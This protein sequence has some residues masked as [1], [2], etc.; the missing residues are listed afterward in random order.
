M[1]EQRQWLVVSYQLTPIFFDV[2]DSRDSDGGKA[3]SDF[4]L[5]SFEFA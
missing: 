4:R 2:F 3:R 1:K 5:R